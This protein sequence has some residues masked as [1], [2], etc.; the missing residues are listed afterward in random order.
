[1]TFP[2]NSKPIFP[3]VSNLQASDC[4]YCEAETGAHIKIS[5]QTV[6]LVSIF[7]KHF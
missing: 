1:M 5:L 7:L 4:V 6:K 2:V 3:T